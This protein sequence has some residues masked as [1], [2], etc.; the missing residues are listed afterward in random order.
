MLRLLVLS[1]LLV[2]AP[3]ASAPTQAD[4][5]V[6]QA[7]DVVFHTSRSRQSA[8][9]GLATRSPWTHVGV[10]DAGPG[11]KPVV[12]EAIGRVSATDW[13]TFRGRGHGDVLVL[14]PRGLDARARARVVA[15]A[16]RFLGRSY[17]ARFGWGDDRLYCSELVA[18]A[19]ARGAK[20]E[21]GKKERLGDLRIGGLEPAIR[22]R[23]GGRVP[24]DLRLVTPASIAADEDLERVYEGR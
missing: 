7:G 2:L 21:L 5:P 22:E 20:V 9:I 19:F 1:C 8:A 17:D 24:R 11:G 3:C 6:L 16:R 12:I 23:W 15:E 4:D 14:R 10:V 13:R 18:K